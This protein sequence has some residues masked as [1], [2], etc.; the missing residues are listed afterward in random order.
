MVVTVRGHPIDRVALQSHDAAIG[1]DIFQ[2]L[3][4]LEGAMRQLPVVGQGDAEHAR[5][6]VH[7]E[8]AAE[9]GPGEE[10]RGREGAGVDDDEEDRVADVLGDPLPSEVHFRVHDEVPELAVADAE[11]PLPRAAKGQRLPR[12]GALR[13]RDC[14]LRRLKR[15]GLARR[16]RERSL[17]RLHRSG[18][19]RHGGG[20]EG[21]RGEGCWGDG[22]GGPRCRSASSTGGTSAREGGLRRQAPDE[23]TRARGGQRRRG[24]RP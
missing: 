11:E 16:P 24:E 18:P 20:Q 9:G 21:G 13:P 2:K 5:D 15:N 12:L 10:P 19:A 1:E 3:R 23:A 8:E 14:A 7:D 17:R 4:G 22:R 6:E